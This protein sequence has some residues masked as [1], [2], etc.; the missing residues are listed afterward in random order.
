MNRD[1]DKDKISIQLSRKQNLNKIL[2]QRF[3][4]NVTDFS[5]VLGK[6]KFFVYGLLWSLDKAASRKITDKTARYIESKLD[7]PCGFLDLDALPEDLRISY[8]PFV[9]MPLSEE[10]NNLNLAQQSFVI[11]ESEL[12]FFRLKSKHLLAIRITSAQIK[13]FKPSDVVIVDTNKREILTNHVYFVKLNNQFIFREVR[14]VFTN[15]RSFI[16]LHYDNTEPHESYI[17]EPTDQ[18]EVIGSPV[19][20]IGPLFL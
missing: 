1:I 4:G 11:S 3:M 7:F 5:K 2:E 18:F 15:G 12:E 14:R 20:Q 13:H 19:M 9:D 16:S 8:I 6:H 10:L 17:V